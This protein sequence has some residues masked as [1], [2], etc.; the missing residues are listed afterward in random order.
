[1]PETQTILFLASNPSETGIIQLEK[2]HSRIS[3]ELQDSDHP[4]SFIIRPKDAVT[5]LDFQESMSR[6][7]PTI[8]HFS[9]HGV[10]GKASLRETISEHGRSL[11]LREDD[12]EDV[13][14]RA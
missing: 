12:P 1:M 5:L 4:Q 7:K 11:K 2:E 9:G 6:E 10:S 3:R 8:V 14:I 13:G